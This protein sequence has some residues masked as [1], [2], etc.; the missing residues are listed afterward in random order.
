MRSDG[1]E[2]ACSVEDLGLMP[3]SGRSLEK[4]MASHSSIPA[5]EIPCTKEAGG[6]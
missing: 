6:Q 1:K 3:G 5:W 2:S 4:K